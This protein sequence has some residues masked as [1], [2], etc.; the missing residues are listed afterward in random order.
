MQVAPEQPRPTLRTA[1]TGPDPK[2]IISYT[3]PAPHTKTPTKYYL[4]LGVLAMTPRLW[5]VQPTPTAPPNALPLC[6]ILGPSQSAFDT[7]LRDRLPGYE[8]VAPSKKDTLW[9]RFSQGADFSGFVSRVR[10]NRM[11][12]PE[13]LTAGELV[14]FVKDKLKLPAELEV[15]AEGILTYEHCVQA[16]LSELDS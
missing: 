14:G 3:H 9:C 16:W 7:F 1:F 11:Q 10:N 2:C 4:T 15:S 12:L 5:L 8:H 13:G 6:I